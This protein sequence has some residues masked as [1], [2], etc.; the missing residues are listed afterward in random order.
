MEKYLK[1]FVLMLATVLS[2]SLSSCGGGDD[3]EPDQPG[4]PSGKYEVV[5][6]TV[7]VNSYFD[8]DFRRNEDGL[9]LAFCKA[10]VFK[11]DNGLYFG[12]QDRYSQSIRCAT[13]GSVQSLS[14]ISN[15]KDL[16]WYGAYDCTANRRLA[17]EEKSGFVI[18]GT[19][20]GQAYYVRVFIDSFNRNASG[21]VIGVNYKLQQFTPAQ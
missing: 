10:G 11:R 4:K 8:I 17:V 9:E 6:N 18:E 15:V 19:Y 13:F 14:A 5:S 3:D 20:D 1:Y 21:E 7:D 2:L 16:V 12:V